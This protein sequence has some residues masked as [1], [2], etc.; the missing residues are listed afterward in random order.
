MINAIEWFKE[1]GFTFDDKI[2]IADV[3]ALQQDAKLCGMKQMAEMVYDEGLFHMGESMWRR[4][5]SEE[6]SNTKLRDATT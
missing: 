6:A 5:E 2:T 1:K 4:I 3:I